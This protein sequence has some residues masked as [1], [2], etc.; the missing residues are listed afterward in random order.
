MSDRIPKNEYDVSYFHLI[1]FSLILILL[2][3]ISFFIGYKTGE[4]K[5][6]KKNIKK[7]EKKVSGKSNLQ[8]ST[9]K[10]KTSIKKA[11]KKVESVKV[12]T[13][14]EKK[15]VEKKKTSQKQKVKSEEGKQK[16][17][18]T[19]T[20]RK[21]YYVQIAASQ[22]LSTAKK[23]AKKYRKYFKV[24]IFYPKPT[25][26]QKWYKLRTGPFKMRKQ[27]KNYLLK[28]KNRYKIKGFIVKVE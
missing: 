8:V 17:L 4:R 1:F 26:D 10:N 18:I 6:C 20:Y 16:K 25:D 3:L 22:D 24:V 13:S 27:A 21:G 23:E 7:V 14:K 28:L 2:L 11:E 9:T 15:I 5:S 12:N 19:Q